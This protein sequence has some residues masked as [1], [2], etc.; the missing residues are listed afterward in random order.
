MVMTIYNEIL[1]KHEN[2]NNNKKIKIKFHLKM[3]NFFGLND[4][5]QLII[6]QTSLVLH[7]LN[8]SQ[9]ETGRALILPDGWVGPFVR[10]GWLDFFFVIDSITIIFF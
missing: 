9:N 4:P 10:F 3:F 2:N 6:R 5:S 8:L 7:I 1:F